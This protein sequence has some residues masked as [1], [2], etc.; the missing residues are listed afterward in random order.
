MGSVRHLAFIVGGTKAYVAQEGVTLEQAYACKFDNV[1]RVVEEC[2]VLDV[3]V[4]TFLLLPQHIQSHNDYPTVVDSLTRFLDDLRSWPLLGQHRIK[5]AVF[6]HWYNVPGRLVDAVK[7]LIEETKDHDAFFFNICLN[8]D[9][10]QEMVDAA[11]IIAQQVRSGKLD[12]DGI[13]AATIKDAIYTSALVPPDIIIKTGMS[14]T[15][16]GFML[17]DGTEAHLHMTGRP[18]QQFSPAALQDVIKEY[19]ATRH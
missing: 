12:P 3:P 19:A 6:G 15:L 14:K 10:K 16:S 11:R 5:V 8:Y 18:W 4:M 7:K 1:K 2:V 17:W 13:S 9:G